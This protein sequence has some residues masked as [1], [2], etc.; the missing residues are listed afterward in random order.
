VRLAGKVALITGAASGMGAAEA[1]L[2]AREGARVAL[3]DTLVEPGRALAM[4]IDATGEGD[5]AGGKAMFLAFD[6]TDDSAWQ[7]AVAAVVER[8]GRLDILVNNAG[9]STTGADVPMSEAE[10]DRLMAVNAKGAFL[11]L[12]HAAPAMQRTGGGAVVN[13][14]SIAAF[15]G[16]AGLHPA[17]GASKAAIVGLTR[18]AAL[19]YAS[20]GIRV[21]AVHPGFMPPMRTARSVDPAWRAR[22]VGQ[23]PMGREGRVDEV[24]AAVLFLAS[25]D[26]SYITG[27]DLAVDGGMLVA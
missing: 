15:K 4:E 21:N 5:A 20:A 23:V 2:F 8:F 12:R 26:S 17:Y 18:S 3:A 11:G 27:A 6:V 9:I 1:R 7:A 25:D 14:G 19:R 10:W 13:I 16:Q 22:M 24:A